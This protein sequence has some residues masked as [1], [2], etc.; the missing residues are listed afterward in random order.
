M[1]NKT[2][3]RR[4]AQQLSARGRARRGE[5]AALGLV[6]WIVPYS[7]GGTQTVYTLGDQPPTNFPNAR[8]ANTLY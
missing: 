7:F 3:E 4:V 6:A 5:M 8:R 2:N 1:A